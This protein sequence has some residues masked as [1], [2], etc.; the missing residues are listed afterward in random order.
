MHI[1]ALKNNAHIVQMLLDKGADVNIVNRN[2]ENQTAIMCSAIT[3]SFEAFKLL[4]DNGADINMESTNKIPTVKGLATRQGRI[5]ILKYILEKVG[6]MYMN[7]F[8]LFECV[9]FRF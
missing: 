5:K 4:L 9:L 3:G 1:A 7:I 6:N 2:R 8:Y